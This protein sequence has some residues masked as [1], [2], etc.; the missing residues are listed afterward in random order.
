VFSKTLNSAN[1]KIEINDL[2]LSKV[3]LY[4]VCYYVQIAKD[5]DSADGLVA[6]INFAQ[7]IVSLN[8]ACKCDDDD[9][10]IQ[11]QTGCIDFF[12][13]CLQSHCNRI[14][15]QRKVQAPKSC[16]IQEI[17][18][19]AHQ[20]KNQSDD[21]HLISGNS[22]ASCLVNLLPFLLRIICFAELPSTLTNTWFHLFASNNHASKDDRYSFTCRTCLLNS[23]TLASQRCS[24]D[25]GSLDLLAQWAL[26]PILQFASEAKVDDDLRHELCIAASLQFTFNIL[27]RTKS[28]KYLGVDS[29]T[30]IES[31]RRTYMFCANI[32][33]IQMD[34]SEGYANGSLRIASLKL[35]LAIASVDQF[36]KSYGMQD[37]LAPGEMAQIFSIL[38]GAANID[39]NRDVRK[40][41]AHV[42]ATLN[43]C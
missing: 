23:F 7:Q 13:T 12:A 39:A 2:E 18:P 20:S 5:E 25:D 32:I 40:L 19:V 17:Y 3:S 42:L 26:P 41:A 43:G 24:E 14:T 21:S 11:L 34:K 9:A 16:L 1:Q 22:V 33:K 36:D 15:R 37:C 28:F 8:N 35:L 10:I 27:T 38:Q 29:L 30:I 31:V 4:I 6:T